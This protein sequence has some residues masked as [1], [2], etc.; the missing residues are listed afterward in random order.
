MNQGQYAWIETFLE[1]YHQYKQQSKEDYTIDGFAEFVR[2]Q[3][4]EEI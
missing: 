1:Y 4:N 3:L 2:D